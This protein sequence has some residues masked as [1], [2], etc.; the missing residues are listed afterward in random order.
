M[1]IR[2]IRGAI[3]VA[4]NTKQ[5]ILDR[6]RDL[7]RSIM[8]ANRIQPD[9]VAA[10]FFSLTTDLNAEFPAY[11]ARKLGWKHVPMLCSCEL[12][13]PGSR[14]KLIRV[15][16]LVNTETPPSRIRHQ[17]LGGTASLRPDLTKRRKKRS[18][19]K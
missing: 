5:Q 4:S 3:N 12:D 8:R 13:V 11:A 1:S 14:R 9:D 18:R 2:G 16:L 17:Y 7:L 10:A 6:T 19:K 15:M